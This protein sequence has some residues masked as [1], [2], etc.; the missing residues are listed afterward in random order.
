MRRS[1]VLIAPIV[2]AMASGCARQLPAQAPSAEP[3]QRAEAS[4]RARAVLEG[5]GPAA[6]PPLPSGFHE[7]TPIEE[8]LS[9]RPYFPMLTNASLISALDQVVGFA[10]LTPVTT[11]GDLTLQAIVLSG[12]G[13][14]AEAQHVALL[15]A[16]SPVGEDEVLPDFLARGGVVVIQKPVGDDSGSAADV[17]AELEERAVVVMVERHDA[18]LVHGD[19]VG[20]NATRP[21]GLHWSD[22]DRDW[23]VS[24]V[25]TPEELISFARELYCP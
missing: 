21:Y 23:S 14:D 18:A 22:G 15:Y 20:N 19:P 10:P 1:V 5:C 13:A 24:G 3:S 16:P 25:T 11:P 7:F 8:R 9:G 4:E 2:V 17:V 12:S 6:L